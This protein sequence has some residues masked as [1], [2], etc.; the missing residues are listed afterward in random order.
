MCYQ[1]RNL[2]SFSLFLFHKVVGSSPVPIQVLEISFRACLFSKNKQEVKENRKG[3]WESANCKF[4]LLRKTQRSQVLLALIK[5]V[6][7]FLCIFIGWDFIAG[8]QIYE[9]VA[10]AVS[11][12]TVNKLIIISLSKVLLLY[13]YVT[14]YHF[15]TS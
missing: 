14:N 4:I 13:V 8:G 15:N 7:T 9:K 1:K 2:S 5:S 10:R 11:F 12:D 6:S 3:R